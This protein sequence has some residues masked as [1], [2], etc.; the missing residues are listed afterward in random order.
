MVP[1]GY[2]LPGQ[3]DLWYQSCRSH[4][5]GWNGA[6]GQQQSSAR[7]QSVGEYLQEWVYGMTNSIKKK[8]IS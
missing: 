2:T 1:G 7:R 3:Q 5:S 8:T 4:S 6:P